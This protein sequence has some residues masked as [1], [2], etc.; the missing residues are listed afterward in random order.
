MEIYFELLSSYFY[1]HQVKAYKVDHVVNHTKGLAAVQAVSLDEILDLDEKLSVG[2]VNTQAV[3]LAKIIS[4]NLDVI[5]AVDRVGVQEGHLVDTLAVDRVEILSVSLPEKII[6]SLVDVPARE[7][8][9]VRTVDLAESL[10]EASAVT[11]GVAL[12]ENHVNQTAVGIANQAFIPYI[13]QN[14]Y[15]AV[16]QIL[17]IL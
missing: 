16:D 9:V 3:G 15:Q 12:G 1:A 17:T 8:A 10:T 14:V 5:Q 6:A 4:V 13:S 7:R 11:Q 2:L